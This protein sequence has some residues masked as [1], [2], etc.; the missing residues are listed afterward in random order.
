VMYFIFLYA[1]F[2]CKK[3][4]T[5]RECIRNAL[6]VGWVPSLLQMLSVVSNTGISGKLTVATK[7]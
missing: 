1:K 3:N 5:S 6:L 2:P 4:Y 7:S